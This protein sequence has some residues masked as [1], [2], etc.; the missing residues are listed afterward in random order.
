MDVC[1]CHDHLD[2]NNTYIQSML[3]DDRAIFF[4][5]LPQLCVTACEPVEEVNDATGAKDL[6]DNLAIVS[7][8]LALLCAVACEQLEEVKGAKG[9]KDYKTLRALERC[10]TEIIFVHT[11]PR[12][13]IEVSKKMNHL[14]KLRIGMRGAADLEACKCILNQEWSAEAPWALIGVR[15]HNF[16]YSS[17]LCR[18]SICCQALEFVDL[19]RNLIS[20]QNAP[21]CV[22]PKTGKVCVPLDPEE[23]HLFDPDTVP[24]VQTLLPQL[25]QQQ[26]CEPRKAHACTCMCVCL[27]LQ[28]RRPSPLAF[29]APWLIEEGWR[30]TDLAPCIE[31]FERKFLS[32]CQRSNR[33]QLGML[34]REAAS[35]ALNSSST[36]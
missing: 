17:A 16:L 2:I 34:S 7:D 26:L 35:Q 22:H 11:Y 24:C 21:F 27:G 25:P 12:L 4:G 19:D 13:D 28:P 20:T 30:S 6:N 10:T 14:L 18:A 31:L 29:I 3:P 32:G 5:T 36:F 23:A 9:A 1:I 15:C 33:S 8:A